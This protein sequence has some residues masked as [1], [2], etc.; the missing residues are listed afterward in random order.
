MNDELKTLKIYAVHAMTQALTHALTH[1]LTQSTSFALTQT[2]SLEYFAY[3][4]A[5]S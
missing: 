3:Y 5:N 4:F 1:A 2:V